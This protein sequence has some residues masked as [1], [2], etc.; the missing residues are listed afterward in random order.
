MRAARRIY[1]GKKEPT[2]KTADQ[3]GENEFAASVDQ[4]N[5]ASQIETEV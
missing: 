5:F 4:E 3:V 1:F 2:P